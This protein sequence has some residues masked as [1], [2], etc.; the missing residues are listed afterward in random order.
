M[1]ERSSSDSGFVNTLGWILVLLAA[2]ATLL[3]TLQNI[4]FW[5]A[6]TADADALAYYRLLAAVPLLISALTLVAAIGLLRRWNWARL[7][8]IGLLVLAIGLQFAAV[9]NAFTMTVPAP[10]AEMAA[11]EAAELEEQAAAAISGVRGFTVV[12]AL[13]VTPLL[14]WLVRRLVSV[15]VR[16]Q[17]LR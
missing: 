1:A 4:T 5:T 10:P 14:I 17:F 9:F 12:L 8:V 13:I 11:A 16:R 3:S 15:P 6:F 7:T 2:I